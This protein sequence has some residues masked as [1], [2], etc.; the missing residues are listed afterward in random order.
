M[1]NLIDLKKE[2]DLIEQ[3]KIRNYEYEL[4]KLKSIINYLPNQTRKT[5]IPMIFNSQLD[6]NFISD[7]LAYILNPK[8]NGLVN[9]PLEGLLNYFK[10][11]NSLEFY[12]EFEDKVEVIREYT[13]KS[14]RRIDLLIFIGRGLVIGIENKI[15]ADEHDEQTKSYAKSIEEEFPDRENLL[16]FL[17]VQKIR[18]ASKK[19]QILTYWDLIHILN[20]IKYDFTNNIR[21]SIFF[22]DFKL[23]LEEFIMKKGSLELSDR[24]NL[25]L[26]N[27]TMINE[28]EES[29]EE[30][31]MRV[32]NYITSYIK[33]HYSESDW[34]FDFSANRGYQQIYKD[35]W[36]R[37]NLYI[38]FEFHKTSEQLIKDNKLFFMVDIE[39]SNKNKFLNLFEK[40]YSKNKNK[41]DDLSIRNCPSSRSH[42]IGYKR[43]DYSIKNIEDVFTQ[44]IKEFNFLINLID[45]TLAE[46]EEKI[47]EVN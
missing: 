17:T 41:F 16:I 12:E 39:K 1:D 44:A 37:K 29:F 46:Y 22:D 33:N 36:K 4:D 43:Y 8:L 20:K 32:F 27:L 2:F 24:T 6:E 45:E 10:E 13:F 5:T 14:N 42:A 34:K 31:S 7:Y 25:Y 38:H 18:P 23:H 30:D 9:K 35:E 28:L 19:F 15:K 11:F 3:K 21:K 47:I 26:E 40:R